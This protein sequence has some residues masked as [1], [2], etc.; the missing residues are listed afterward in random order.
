MHRPVTLAGIAL[1]VFLLA[2]PIGVALWVSFTPAGLAFLVTHLPARIGPARIELGRVSGTLADGLE[3]E[4]FALEHELVSVRIE[5]LRARVGLLPLLW[6]TIDLH[7]ASAGEV[8]VA[9]HRRLKP[10]RKSPLHFLPRLLTL[11]SDEL[12]IANATVV[13]VNG[14][15]LELSG[16]EGAGVMRRDLIRLYSTELHWGG[17]HGEGS[18]DLVAAEPLRLRGETRWTW[19][20][21]GQP[22]WTLEANGQGDLR[23]L[24]LRGGF[25]APFRARLRGALHDLGGAW[26]WAG[27]AEVQDFDLRA[28]GG[29][30]ALG[31][32]TGNLDLTG[33]AAG[34]DANGTLDSAGLAVGLFD[35]SLTGRY[36]ERV[37]T[38]SR[39]VI[40]HRG[41]RASVEGAGDI[42]IVGNG[43]RLDLRGTWRDFRWPLARREVAF[44]SPS[45][46]FTLAGLWPYAVSLE[47]PV[48]VP[49]LPEPIPM[50]VRGEL[51]KHDLHVSAGHAELLRGS[52][53]FTS[54][55]TWSP[56]ESWSV[57][58]Q[59]RGADPGVLRP[60]F[61]GRL[62]FAFNARGAPFGAAGDLEASFS[63]LGGR[64]RG[65]PAGGAG[66]LSRHHEIWGFE[67]LR[68]EAGKL[69]L[70]LDGSLGSERDLRFDVA[71]DDLAILRPESRGSI[72]ARG[73]LRG[74]ADDPILKFKGSGHGIRHAGVAVGDFEAEVDYD[75]R[76]D[77]ESQVQ[78]R[79]TEVEVGG[80]RFDELR[81]RLAGRPSRYALEGSLRAASVR[82][83]LQA[84]GPVGADGWRGTISALT[85]DDGDRVALALDAPAALR[86]SRGGVDAQRLCLHDAAVRLCGEGAW[87]ASAGWTA[88]VDATRLPMTTLTA[89]ITP[90]VSYLGTLDVVAR[91]RSDASGVAVGNLRAELRDAAIRHVAPN[92][93]AEVLALGS[94]LFTLEA[95]PKELHAGFDLDA[96]DKGNLHGTV[97]LQRTEGPWTEMPLHADLKASTDAIG[98]VT[99]YLPDIDRAA[100]RLDAEVVAGGVLG[101]PTL[102][103][104]LNLRQGQLDLYQINLGL[105]DVSL[106][107]HFLDNRLDLNAQAQAGQGKAEVQG[108]IAWVDGAPRGTLQLRG[109]ELRVVNIPEARIFASPDLRFAIE[110]RHIDVKGSVDVPYARLIPANLTGAV[111]PSGDEVIVGAEPPDPGTQFRVRSEITLKLGD[112]VSIDTSGL[113]GRLTGSL[114]ATADGGATTAGR[115][116]LSVEEGKYVAYGRKLDI[117]RGRLLFNGGSVT[118]PA[119]DI[120]AIKQFP[121]IKAGVNVRGT[122]QAQRITFFSDPPVPQSQ[123]VS[124]LLAGGSLESLQGTTPGA[125]AAGQNQNAAT[126]N[127][128]LAQGGAMLAQQLGAK[129]GLEDVGLESN[130]AN[131][132]SLV[133][134]KYLSPRLYVSYGIGIT[135]AVSG[136]MTRY[137]LN[138]HWTIRGQAGKVNSSDLVY[139]IEK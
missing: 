49:A 123:I 60:E 30:G 32:V 22:S 89:G 64:L 4:H 120:R 135:Q 124:L 2:A 66:R 126:R 10:S 133:L 7:Q 26:H 79:A 69:R 114:T 99:A 15:R 129:I 125:A 132:T 73:E 5:H 1:I 50:T 111:L 119:I 24:D 12:R 37:L 47:G 67:G 138:E 38:A 109:T 68:L 97:T 56:A 41:S 112:R 39:I 105:R 96:E 81:L 59:M 8:F 95:Q 87:N 134:G 80:R 63:G 57:S 106:E 21:S 82:L 93:R 42:G 127:E 122:L 130:L 121:D 27:A 45:G 131:E 76:A 36:A 115:G 78:A 101:A 29:G 113:T 25:T 85:I 100:G 94:G 3:L 9:V 139:T 92:G 28:W 128:L 90:E 13:L 88:A 31:R 102:S 16:L 34:F 72:R 74:T 107:A 117:E 46:R 118:D 61:P 116:E 136:L 18:L 17:V 19:Q 40:T 108:S 54:L 77:R 35:V 83:A 23:E 44:R 52:A 43:P 75:P 33:D 71:A 51:S 70:A 62:D 48:Q 98:F 11:R 84:A 53:E 91:A 14:V 86:A 20:P 55:V 6:Q 110:G 65:A 104:V 58:G 137:I 103:G